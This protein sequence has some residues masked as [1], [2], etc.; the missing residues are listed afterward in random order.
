ME[1]QGPVKDCFITYRYWA[2][3]PGSKATVEYNDHF[4]TIQ[5][6]KDYFL[7]IP[8]AGP[9]VGYGKR[10]SYH[11][12]AQRAILLITFTDQSETYTVE[13]KTA[14]EMAIF[15]D[16]KVDIAKELGYVTKR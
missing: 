7:R 16:V 6:L 4:K 11:T 15:L 14:K 10:E 9:L 5:K 3:G 12:W 1:I 8:G 2:L 13:F